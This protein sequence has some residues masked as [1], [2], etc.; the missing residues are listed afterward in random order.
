MAFYFGWKIG[1][2]RYKFTAPPLPPQRIYWGEFL[3]YKSNK[4]NGF[5]LLLP[6][7]KSPKKPNKAG[8]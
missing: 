5:N 3:I 6:K 4:V 8:L 7:E 2:I 1:L